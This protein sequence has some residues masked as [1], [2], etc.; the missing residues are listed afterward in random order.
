[1]ADLNRKRAKDP[2]S[3]R[4]SISDEMELKKLAAKLGTSPNN[5]ARALTSKGIQSLIYGDR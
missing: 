5:V 1:M 4:L 2:I 3:F